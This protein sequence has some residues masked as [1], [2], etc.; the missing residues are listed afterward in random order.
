[1]PLTELLASILADAGNAPPG[2]NPIPA[3]WQ[4]LR[5]LVI[6]LGGWA[7]ILWSLAASALRRLDKFSTDVT[8]HLQATERQLRGLRRETR[9]ARIN[10]RRRRHRRNLN[11]T[12][13]DP[14]STPPPPTRAPGPPPG[15]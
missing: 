9:S 2:G 4:P 12:A 3:D 7:A 14:P 1:M 10:A 8:N 13:H 5:D 15:V 11:Q 6:N